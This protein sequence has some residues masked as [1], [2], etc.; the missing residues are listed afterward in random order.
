MLNLARAF[1]N[2][3]KEILDFA[4]PGKPG[5]FSFRFQ[6]SL[7]D[8]F[9]KTGLNPWCKLYLPYG[10]KCFY[11][12]SEQINGS[13]SD[14]FFEKEYSLFYD[15]QVARGDFVIDVGAYVGLYSLLSA[16]LAGT[17]GLVVSIEPEFHSFALLT[18]NLKLNNLNRNTLARNLA[19][20]DIN[21]RRD[22][23]VP[24]IASGSTFH[25][26]HLLSQTIR[27]YAKTSV[28][29]QTCDRLLETLKIRHVNIMKIDVEGAELSVLRGA[30]DALR[31]CRVDRLVIEIHKTVNKPQT[32]T[33]YLE[34]RGYITD[35]YIDIN[36]NKGMLYASKKR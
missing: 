23:Y 8:I 17:D 33:G 6:T 18:N 9:N 2:M 34:S 36:E 35:A 16:K 32:V 19:L 20:S 4:D 24:K 27:D 31:N 14:V 26:D 3:R 15:Y 25:L 1:G 30:N 22:F 29:T 5:Y 10:L 11:N 7:I 28:E 21:G 12:A 13:I